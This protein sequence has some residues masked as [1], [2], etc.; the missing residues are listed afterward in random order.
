MILPRLILFIL[1]ILSAI[2]ATGQSE[3]PAAPQPEP[4]P[5]PSSIQYE[6]GLRLEVYFSSLPQG[7]VGLLRL[8]GEGI[9]DAQLSFRREEYP[10]FYLKDDAWYGLVV[11]DM[12]VSPRV[13]DLT[14][15][16]ERAAG[17]VTFEREIRIESAGY[18]LQEF[19]LPASRAYLADAEIEIEEF[20][21]IDAITAEHSPEP[22]WDATGFE[23]PLAGDL[24][25]PFGTFRVL[26]GDRET[27][28]TGWDQNAPIGT[29]IRALAAGAIA[30]AGQLDIR[31]NYVMIDHGF[32]IFSGYAHFSEMQ[33]EAGQRVAAGQIIGKSGNSG[34]SSAPHLHWEIVIHGRWVDGLS[35]LELW[36]PARS[37]DE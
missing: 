36:L 27:R 28:H 4:R 22:L 16:A 32:G 31:G 8:E 23:L 30:F 9:D 34:R 25:S 20:A 6:A 35:F 2:C 13:Y 1:V 10:F 37:S 14:V 21:A 18:I 12:T 19:D 24:S 26:N 17:D 11:V 29:P 33:V 15:L 7:G 3:L 5:M